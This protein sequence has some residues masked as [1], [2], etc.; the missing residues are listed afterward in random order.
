[1]LTNRNYLHGDMELYLGAVGL[2]EVMAWVR[3][4]LFCC[5]ICLLFIF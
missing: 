3:T 4:S 2:G 1:M 5:Y